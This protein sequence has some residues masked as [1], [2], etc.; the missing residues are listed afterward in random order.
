MSSKNEIYE[1]INENPYFHLASL[2][3]DQP[4]VRTILL[5]RADEN[6]IIFHTGA[7]KDLFKQL[8]NNPRVEMCFNNYQDNIQ[9]R[10]TGITE[11]VDDLA[12]KKEIVNE[13]DFLKPFIEESGYEM[14]AVYRVKDCVATIWTM[15]NNLEPKKYIEL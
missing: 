7:Q 2:E 8:G 10:I 4:R 5:Y 11:L 13:R 12:I 3:G 15:A 14:L 9:V 6:G 1:F